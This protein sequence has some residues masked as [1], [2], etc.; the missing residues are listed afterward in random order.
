M[1][2]LFLN[3][4]HRTIVSQS[5]QE[6]Y[7]LGFMLGSLLRDKNGID[8]CFHD[9]VS[10][11]GKSL[12]AKAIVFSALGAKYP[13]ARSKFS[14]KNSL[15]WIFWTNTNASITQT[16]RNLDFTTIQCPPIP[17]LKANNHNII[18]HASEDECNNSDIVIQIKQSLEKSNH[19]NIKIFVNPQKRYTLDFMS[20][21]LAVDE[22]IH[23]LKQTLTL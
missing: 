9:S 18:E 5:P 8:I 21:M 17:S 4:P 11:V 1:A 23:S 7:A 15:A 19:R 22:N 6:T 20:L 2:L 12:T 3:N 10:G 13:K 14:Y 16:D